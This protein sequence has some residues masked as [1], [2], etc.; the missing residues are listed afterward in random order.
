MNVDLTDLLSQISP[1][2][3]PMFPNIGNT[4][5]KYELITIIVKPKPKY[6]PKWLY[7]KILYL[8]FGIKYKSKKQ[9]FTWAKINLSEL[10][11]ISHRDTI[12][13]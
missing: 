7:T 12:G 5:S 1:T 3:M 2:T 9:F 4:L 11:K 6:I 8:F 13:D 10:E